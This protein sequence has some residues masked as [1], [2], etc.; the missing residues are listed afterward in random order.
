VYTQRLA[1]AAADTSADRTS[2][3]V[4]VG[5]TEAVV[6]VGIE[7]VVG[8]VEAVGLGLADIVVGTAEHNCIVL[9]DPAAV[10]DIAVEAAAVAADT[11][12][13]TADCRTVA[14]C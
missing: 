1:A 9:V 8:I 14:T 7:V 2:A 3:V 13:T 12:D 10:V 11:A 4:V 6:A 5:G